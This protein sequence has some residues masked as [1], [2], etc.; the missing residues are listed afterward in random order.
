MLRI[1]SSFSRDKIINNK[2]DVQIKKGGP[3]FYINN[4]FKKNKFPYLLK[5]GKI[6]NVEIKLENNEEIGK[7]K[8]KIKS[9]KILFK[10][11]DNVILV[12]T[13]GKEWI[14]NS[15]DD[16]KIKVFLDIQGYVRDLDFFGKKKFFNKRFLSHIFCLKGTEEELKHI[17]K[18]IIKKQKN[19]CLLITKGQEGSVVFSKKKKFIFK[20]SKKIISRDTIGAGDTF[21]ANFVLNF[22]KTGDEI[23]AT[24]KIAT[25]ETVEFLM[26][27]AKQNK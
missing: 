24:G 22:I 2:G 17:P 8:E 14:L 1:Y 16:K 26:Q 27:H 25:E 21:F 13:I 23:E 15:I 20:P 3:A 19:K 9:Q 11:T 4:V 6:I 7:V 5:I 12:S 18:N 10:N